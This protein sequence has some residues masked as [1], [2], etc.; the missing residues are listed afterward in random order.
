MSLRSHNNVYY[1]DFF[2]VERGFVNFLLLFFYFLLQFFLLG[3][4]VYE[5]AIIE[6]KSH[7]LLL[8]GIVSQADRKQTTF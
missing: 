6:V 7:Q 5:I 4:E 2:P 1:E 8:I 3:S